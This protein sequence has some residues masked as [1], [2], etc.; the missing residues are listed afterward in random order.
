M[1][2]GSCLGIAKIWSLGE[3]SVSCILV[4]WP[5]E[6]CLKFP[7]LVG[8]LFQTEFWDASL[9]FPVSW[10]HRLLFEFVFYVHVRNKNKTRKIARFFGKLNF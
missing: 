10:C 1:A 6:N 5:R 8:V 4:S 3:E 9:G 2:N 7:T